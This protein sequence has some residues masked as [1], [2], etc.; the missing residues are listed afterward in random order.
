[1]RG[2]RGRCWGSCTSGRVSRVRPTDAGKSSG[3]QGIERPRLGGDKGEHRSICLYLIGYFVKEH[4][5]NARIDSLLEVQMSK[6]T[7]S[8]I[9][10]S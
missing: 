8:P 6:T 9:T 1:M 7:H 4:K 3:P 2:M 5:R 10:E